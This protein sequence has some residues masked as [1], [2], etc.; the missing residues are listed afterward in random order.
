MYFSVNTMHKS[1][2][3]L[4]WK[5][6]FHSIL[7]SSIFHTEISVPYHALPR[8]QLFQSIYSTYLTKI[9]FAHLACRLFALILSAVSLP[10]SFTLKCR[11][12]ETSHFQFLHNTCRN[13]LVL[14]LKTRK[15]LNFVNVHFFCT[16]FDSFCFFKNYKKE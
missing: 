1:S 6:V 10:S 5:I 3:E 12:H 15:N 16:F 11:L 9:N 13:E 7:A 8:T 14:I 2:M 4:V